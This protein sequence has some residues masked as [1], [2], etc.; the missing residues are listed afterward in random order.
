MQNSLT[1]KKYSLNLTSYKKKRIPFFKSILQQKIVYL[2][3]INLEKIMK[4]I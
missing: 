1:Q 4:H 3:Y 2:S